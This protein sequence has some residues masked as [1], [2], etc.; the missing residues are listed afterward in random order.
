[1]RRLGTVAVALSTFCSSLAQQGSIQLGSFPAIGV[2][3]GRSTVT[4]SAEVRDGVG[5]L[6]RDGT[7]VVFESDR[8]SFLSRNVVPTQAGLA[9]I[10]LVAPSQPGTARVRATVFSLNVANSLEIEFFADRSLLDS[11][12]DYIELVSPGTV[13][14]S[15]QHRLFEAED[16]DG[17]V[18]VK[19][20]D[21][22]L[23]ASRVQLT[24]STYELR[25]SGARLAI[26]GQEET[27][28]Q[29]YMRLDRRRGFGVV[30]REGKYMRVKRVGVLVSLEE[31]EGPRLEIVEVG[32]DGFARGDS[33]RD[34]RPLGFQDVSGAVSRVR[35]KKA[36]VF[37]SSQIQFHRAALTVGDQSVL[38]LPLFQLSTSSSAPLVTEQFV[39]VSN[40]SLNVNYPHYVS[41]R[42]GETSLVRFRYGHRSGTGLGSTGGMFVDYEMNWNRGFDQQGGLVVSG[43]ARDDW[44][45][46]LRQAWNGKTNVSAQLDFPAHRSMFANVGLSQPLGAYRLSASGQHG[47]SISGERFES[48]QFNVSLERTPTPLG[49]LPASIAYG[50]TASS[51]SLRGFGSSEQV[52]MDVRVD[53]E[54]IE[55]GATNG[56]RL[57]G[58]LGVVRGRNVDTPF[59]RSASATW[60]VDFGNGL[61]ASTGY[62]YV[63]DGFTDEVL[64]A[65]RL[66]SQLYWRGGPVSASAYLTKSLDL[67]RFSLSGSLDYRFSPL[68]RLGYGLYTDRYDGDLFSEQTIVLGY[69]LGFREVGLSYSTRTR[70]LGLE[71][72]GTRF[73]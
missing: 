5:R 21:I 16:A 73:Q 61:V 7:Q 17:R 11:A 12:Q 19:Y 40:S 36:V 44:S 6:V 58:A 32:P 72:L 24:A 48:N 30:V 33:S 66:S 8:G 2:A 60:D 68:W 4:L 55:F 1:L 20:R 46:G 69:R 54:P 53:S 51:R 52:A 59:T 50:L 65:H 13:D 41:L 23:T 14:Y 18:D 22:G 39:N 70:R 28:Q 67:D 35:A 27:F 45:V 71:L 15:P 37:P 26:G 31:A 49:N 64:G 38:S 47:R 3:D 9:K 63:V 56:L 29:L 57:S 10:V 42:P 43:L 62:E 34:L 25:A